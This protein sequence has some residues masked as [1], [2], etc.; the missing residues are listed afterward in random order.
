MNDTKAIKAIK[1]FVIDVKVN[2]YYEKIDN[3][4]ANN[5]AEWFL[6][7]G[8]GGDDSFLKEAL[9]KKETKV[10]TKVE[11]TKEEIKKE[12]KTFDGFEKYKQGDKK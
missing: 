8:L 3:Q 9:S 5:I 7:E 6:K 2:G 11:E 12:D 10:E 4:D 1:N